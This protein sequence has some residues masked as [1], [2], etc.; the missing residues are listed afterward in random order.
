[1]CMHFINVLVCTCVFSYVTSM[2]A[3]ITVCVYK[4]YVLHILAAS[5]LHTVFWGF[6]GGGWFLYW[7]SV[8]T[9]YQLFPF[10]LAMTSAFFLS[11]V[12]SE[13]YIQSTKCISGKKKKRRK[14]H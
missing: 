10:P 11:G 12:H 9:P 5:I 13:R 14:K 7:F 1:M 2:H 6:F 4:K 3:H 8:L